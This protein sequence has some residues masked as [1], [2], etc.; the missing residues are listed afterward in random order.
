MTKKI[1]AISTLFLA[2]V[3]A[4]AFIYNF[5][6][7]KPS[8]KKE[9]GQS[10]VSKNAPAEEGKIAD[11]G[12]NGGQAKTSPPGADSA[13]S[14]GSA[15]SGES[16]I[17][18]VSDE[19]VFGAT[20]SPDGKFVYYFLASS[21]QLNQV[22]LDGKL[23]K[24]LSTEKYE[25]I[26]KILWNRQKNAAIIKTKNPSG[27]IKYLTHNLATKKI[28]VLKENTD[29]V[30]WSNM[31]DKIVYKYFDP[32]TK[33]RT[34]SLSDPDGKNWKGLAD[35]NFQNVEIAPVPNSSDISFWPTADAHLS[36]VVGTAPF[37]G[38]DK[39][40]ILHDRFGADFLWSPDGGSAAVSYTDQKGGHKT[41]LATMDK[42]GNRFQPLGFPTFVSKCAWSADSKLLFC[43]LPG[44]IP[45]AAVLP[46]DWREGKIKTADTFWKIEMAGGK[47]QRLVDTEK[48]SQSFDV[49]NPFLSKDEK[50]LFFVNKADGKLYK[51]SI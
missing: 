4:F 16:S 28:F 42:S 27:K 38:G 44:N 6:F 3:V 34:I 8:S 1:F 41:D 43:A 51:L 40:E 11:T 33:K 17:T 32:K 20:I 25:N 30:A 39:W 23:D 24:V 45:E 36:T 13:S 7:K 2:F 21:G 47:K 46:N 18:A 50:A 31:G 15:A 48:I 35:F 26:K 22:S 10:T 19:P 9:S 14:N 49:L 5:V 29:S 37:G 12:K